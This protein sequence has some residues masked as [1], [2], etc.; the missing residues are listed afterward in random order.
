MDVCVNSLCACHDCV[1]KNGMV[2]VSKT[3]LV[4]SLAIAGKCV[5][6]ADIITHD[7][8]VPICMEKHTHLIA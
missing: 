8:V 5:E 3:R 7:D 2:S 1:P 4:V 6:H